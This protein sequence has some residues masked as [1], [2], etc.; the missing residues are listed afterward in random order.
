M[1]AN[2]KPGHRVTYDE[3]GRPYLWEKLDLTK[4]TSHV[5][6]AKK[7]QEKEYHLRGEL[8]T[9]QNV[10]VLSPDF[11]GTFNVG[12]VITI[13]WVNRYDD[14][15]AIYCMNTTSGEIEIE[16]A[17]WPVG[18][19]EYKWTIPAGA[20]GANKIQLRTPHGSDDSDMEFTVNP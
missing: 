17:I 18:Y 20:A 4:A 1:T 11:G 16:S 2:N 3:Y 14:G 13:S 6:Y 19:N 8:Q 15:V 12:D 7:V 10:S 9:G 5:D